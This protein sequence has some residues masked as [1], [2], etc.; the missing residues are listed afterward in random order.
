MAV[1][2]PVRLRCRC[3]RQHLCDA[4]NPLHV[5]IEG[6]QIFARSAAVRHPRDY[7]SLLVTPGISFVTVLRYADTVASVE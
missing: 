2:R 7:P 5:V 1:L 6:S 3:S 4:A